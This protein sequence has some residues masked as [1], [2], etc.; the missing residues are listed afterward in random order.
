MGK[1]NFRA[2]IVWIPECEHDGPFE[3]ISE[4]PWEDYLYKNVCST[5]KGCL[6]H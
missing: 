1:L 2:T 5:R 4:K 6:S 3:L